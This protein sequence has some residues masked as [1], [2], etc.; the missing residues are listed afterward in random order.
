MADPQRDFDVY[1]SKFPQPGRTTMFF[2]DGSSGP[3]RPEAT[4]SGDTHPQ[5]WAD[6]FFY[7]DTEENGLIHYDPGYQGEW[8]RPAVSGDHWATDASA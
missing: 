1:A 4:Y 7:Y 8:V 5:M 6:G 3:T 2:D